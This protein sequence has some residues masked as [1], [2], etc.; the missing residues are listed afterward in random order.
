MRILSIALGGCLKAPPIAFGITG[1]TGG[2]LTYLWG[3]AAALADRSDV[4]A[5]E[6]AT[7]LIDDPALGPEYARPREQVGA[8]LS[9]LRIATA[10]TAYLSKEAAAADRPAFTAALIAELERRAVLPDIVHA[11]FADAADV[12][13]ALRRRFGIPFVFTAHSLGMDKAGCGLGDPDPRAR[14]DLRARIAAEDAAIA[15][16]DAIVASS[17]DEAERQLMAYPGADAARIHR[18]PPGAVLDGGTGGEGAGDIARAQ[19]LVAPFLRHPAR[20]MLLAIARPVRKKN[21]PALVDLYAADADLRARANLVIVAGLRDGPDSGEDEQRA[22]VRDLLHRLDAHDL[23]GSLALPKRHDQRDIAALYALARRTGGVF[24]NPALTEPYG[25]TLTEA[26]HH[27]VPVVATCHGGAAD[28]VATLGH[29]SV[30]DPGDPAAFAAAIRAL[31]DDRAAWE[32]ASL[33]GREQARSLSWEGYAERFVQIARGIS[34]VPATAAAIDAMPRGDD[35]LLCDIDHTLTGCRVGAGELVAHLAATPGRLFGIATGRS[36]QEAQR[37]LREWRYP[38]PVVW[39]TSVGSEIYWRRG[40]RVVADT[41]YAAHLTD[42]WRPDAIAAIV[43]DYPQATPQAAVEQRRFKRSWFAPD[44]SVAMRIRD[45]IAREG[46]AARVVFSHGRFLDILPQRSGKSG[47][48]AWVAR[49]SG[50]ALSSVYAAGDSGNDLDMLEACP[51]AILVA[52]HSAELAPLIGR[53]GVHVAT[54]P[55]AGGV[56]EGVAA[57]SARARMEAAA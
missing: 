5:V 19:A 17:R 1:D 57:L 47:A 27:G 31:L 7:R 13:I 15:A 54:R 46:L 14:P 4:A 33:R 3:A 45:R 11:H 56:V 30:A 18:V 42:D 40:A 6:I 41:G 53:K 8:K 34:D 28:I 32:A 10:D 39:I 48:M 38:D 50:I 43:A 25:L 52:N 23:Y 51:N 20:P 55:H 37:I 36:L 21:L 35:L 2:H 26:A 9:I 22:V 44:Q 49:R 16:A 29:G 24:V 12:A